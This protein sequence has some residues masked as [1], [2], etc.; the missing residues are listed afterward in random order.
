MLDSFSLYDDPQSAHYQ[1]PKDLSELILKGNHLPIFHEN[2]PF[3]NRP[4]FIP[5]YKPAGIS[6]FDVIRQVRSTLIRL[7]GKGKGRRKLKIGHFGTLD[8]FAE[9]ILIIGTGKAMKLMNIVQEELPKRYTALGQMGKKTITG[10]CDGE[11][12]SE[13]DLSQDELNE[14]YPKIIHQAKGLIGEY[15]QAPPYYSAVKHEGKALYEYAREGVFIDKEPVQR[16]IYNLELIENPTSQM[17][18]ASFCA[19][20]SNGTYIRT[21]WQDMLTDI[22]HHGHLTQLIRDEVGGIRLEHTVRPEEFMDDPK[23]KTLS[24]LDVIQL[25]KVSLEVEQVLDLMQGREISLDET[26][27]QGH[28]WIFYKSYLIGIG[29]SMDGQNLVKVKTLLF[30]Q[31]KCAQ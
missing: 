13:I 21:L 27:P 9:G 22:D 24:P 2:L 11:L 3:D 8:P 1:N 23:Q 26:P 25:E 30:S 12:M 5:L 7:L 17:N 29:E 20:V 6:S 15:W 14:L 10:D 19:K 18:E 31:G 16:F 28:F 4:Y